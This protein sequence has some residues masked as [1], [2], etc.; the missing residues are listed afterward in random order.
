M[1]ACIC[2]RARAINRDR[3][4]QQRV[5]F[6]SKNTIVRQMLEQIAPHLPPECAL[7]VRFD[8]WYASKKLLK[9]V[10]RRKWQFTCRVKSSRKLNRTRLDEQHRKEKHK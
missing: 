10:H 9:F 1:S 2:A 7:I 8:S 3:A 4:P 6:G 5:H